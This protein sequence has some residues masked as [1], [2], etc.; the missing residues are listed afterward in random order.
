[1]LTF[2]RESQPRKIEIE[3]RN[4]NLTKKIIKEEDREENLTTNNEREE[5]EEKRE[6]RKII[7]FFSL[8]KNI[9]SINSQKLT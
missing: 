2:K 3:D 5:E 6:N 8:S 1:M 9:M 7:D 4:G